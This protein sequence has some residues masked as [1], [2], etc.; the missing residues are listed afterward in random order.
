MSSEVAACTVPEEIMPAL[1]PIFHYFGMQR[2]PPDADRF[3]P[4]IEPSRTFA[5]REDG[6]GVGGS[7]S[8]RSDRPV[9]GGVVRAAGLTLVGVLPT[10]RRRGILRAMMRAQLDD[11]HRRREPVGYLWASED[12]IYGQ[13]GYG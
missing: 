3:L 5:A 10:H 8:F 13:F 6:A 1:T 12:T 9:P 2:T 7:A 11:V 4:F